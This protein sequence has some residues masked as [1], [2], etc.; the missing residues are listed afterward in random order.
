MAEFIRISEAAKRLGITRARMYQM[1]DEK[2]LPIIEIL[3][4]KTI[5]SSLLDSDIIKKRRTTRRTI[6][7]A[8]HLTSA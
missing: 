8:K 6:L 4:I 5:D 7:N 1:I 2:D 3:G